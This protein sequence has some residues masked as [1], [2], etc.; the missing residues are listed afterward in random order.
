M[1]ASAD[2]RGRATIVLATNRPALVRSCDSVV[3]FERGRLAAV[4][5]AD[6]LTPSGARTASA[7]FA[8]HRRA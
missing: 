5:G 7:P 4:G 2:S 1:T 3:A 6:L 8:S